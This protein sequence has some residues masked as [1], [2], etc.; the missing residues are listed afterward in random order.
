M[1]IPL[2]IENCFH[3]FLD[4]LFSKLPQE[5]PSLDRL[6]CCKIISHRGEHDNISVLENTLPAFDA[7]C[8][9]GVGGIEFD[10]RWTK[11]LI[12]VVIHDECTYRVFKKDVAIHKVKFSE[13]NERIPLIPKFED[14]IKKFGRK[15]HLMIEL[16]SEYYPDLLEQKKILK[17][18]L[19]HLEEGKD[20]HILSL[21][22]KMFAKVD[23]LSPKSFLPVAELNTKELSKLSSENG[24]AGVA[25]HYFFLKN[26]IIQKHHDQKQILGTG[27]ISSMPCL[28]RE[29]NRNVDFIFTNSGKDLM[30]QILLEK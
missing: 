11:D 17:S 18:I 9:A 6:K 19:G 23:F 24:W 14:V 5:K 28:Y 13:L 2:W 21:D 10:I 4:S 29:I 1:T 30:N 12:P 22:P 27:F 8:E 25:G 26:K 16:K 15:I 20:F 3:L 7:A